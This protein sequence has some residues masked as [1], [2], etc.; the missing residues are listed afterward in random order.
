M[1][2]Y[3]CGPVR[4]ASGTVKT[5]QVQKER[6]KEKRRVSGDNAG[7]DNEGIGSSHMI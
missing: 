4:G 2:W 1:V 5:K 3:Q 6:K 7:D